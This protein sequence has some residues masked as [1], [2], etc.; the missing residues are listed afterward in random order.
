MK[1]LAL[2]IPFGKMNQPRLSSARLE[3]G[4]RVAVIGGGPAGSFFSYFLLDFAQ[5][6][7]LK[8]QVDVYEP[9]DFSV[10]GPAGCN[11]CAGIVS[12]SVIQMLAVEGVTFPP[13]VVQRGMD[14]YVVYTDAGKA[15]LET[16]ALEKR[17]GTVFRG[18]GPLGIQGNEWRSFD[19]FL[20]EKAVQKGANLLRGRVEEVSRLEDGRVQVKTR[21]GAAQSYDLLAVSAG[22]NTNIL[23]IFQDVDADYRQ[24]GLVQTFTREYYLGKKKIESYLGEHTIHFF[25]LNI[26]GLDFAAIV[27]KGDYVTVALLG[28]GLNKDV[29]EAFLNSSP[30]KE[31][32]P[33]DWKPEEYACH[34][35][36][37]INIHGAAHP[38]A[39]RMVVLGDAGISRLYK[40]GIGAAYRAAK[41]AAATAV[42]QGIGE[43]DFKRDFWRS[44][45]NME[46]DNITGKVL[47]TVV[48]LIK[49]RRF[50]CHAFVQM[51]VDEQRKPADQRRM[52]RF[53]W[54]MC[55]GSAP[56]REIFLSAFNPSFL[57]Q[58]LL[59]LGSSLVRRTG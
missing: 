6:V 47:F 35:S 5:K 7:D 21:G 28:D 15:R 32:M 53:V 3:D 25:M 19:G 36:P 43:E 1:K 29:F 31:C 46:Y 17:I 45:R 12:E 54:G 18:A 9:R 44:Y 24:P 59:H 4:S 50:A 33:P 38:Y 51:M 10:A 26:P 56:Y 34:C 13:T 16:P 42:L 57:S 11:M 49:P 27:P 52:S 30:V 37:R 14:T 23:K 20:L 55:T 2:P 8:L 58:W 48:R 41:Y 39:E 22:V 40:D